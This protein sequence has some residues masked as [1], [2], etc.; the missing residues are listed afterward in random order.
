MSI[1]APKS[2]QKIWGENSGLAFNIIYQEL[3]RRGFSGPISWK[4]KTSISFYKDT[5]KKIRIYLSLS[6]FSFDGRFGNFDCC[7]VIS[8]KTIY[9][10]QNNS[11][12]WASGPIVTEKL[13]KEYIPCMS[14]YL[15]HFKWAAN[16]RTDC[17]YWTM[18]YENDIANNLYKCSL[19]LDE[20]FSPFLFDLDSDVK[21]YDA[22][23]KSEK[24]VA[25][26][27]AKSD[28][29]SFFRHERKEGPFK[30]RK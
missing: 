27:W 24:Y 2:V 10:N 17:P 29:I 9:E 13:Y 26:E 5:S 3:K 8:S 14:M 20:F 15:S 19:D 21:L 7:L 22:I 6:R 12:P 11:S 16:Y 1:L 28:G 23:E 18:T 25:P 4:S 30:T